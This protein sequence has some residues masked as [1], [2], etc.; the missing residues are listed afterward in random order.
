MGNYF[1]V[2][3]DKKESLSKRCILKIKERRDRVL[4]G[5]IN[6]IPLPFKR[7]RNTYPGAEKGR[8]VLITANQK[9]GKSKL[10]DFIFMYEPFFYYLEHPDELR[11]KV[12]Y[13][14]L[15]I[16]KSDKMNEF[17]CH[18]LW[19]LN[20]IRISTNDLKSVDK[21]KPLS[22]EILD[23]LDS[24]KYQYYINEFEKIVDFVDNIKHPTGIFSYCKDYAL[25]HG[26]YVY[27]NGRHKNELTDEWEDAQVIDYYEPND[28]DEYVIIIEDNASNLMSEKGLE[29]AATITKMSKYN[30]D[31]RDKFQFSPVLI[32]HQ[33]QQQESLDNFKSGKLKPSPSGLADCKTTIRDINIAISIYSPFKHEIQQYEGYDITKFKNNIRFMEIMEDRDN[34]GGGMICPLF[35][36]GATSFF[37]ELPLP[38]ETDKIKK[39]YAM[40]DDIRNT[41]IKKVVMHFN[42]NTDK[43]KKGTSKNYVKNFSISP[44]WVW[45]N[46]KF[47]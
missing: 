9:V 6:S 36:D 42:T 30:I 14:T 39:V 10:S 31:L 32:Q 40:L 17:Y 3:E 5:K 13:F 28:P 18:L 23:L 1:N 2:M 34:G 41:D 7:F 38:N 29:I 4:S 26:K 43:I 33:A 11:L 15:E 16:N 22:Q 20:R 45:K 19:R 24:E 46:L 27:K 12:I 8:Y 47:W 25:N 21:D 37:A 44:K 35:F